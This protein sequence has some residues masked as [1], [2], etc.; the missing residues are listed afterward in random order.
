MFSCWQGNKMFSLAW[1]LLVFF[2]FSLKL[3]FCMKH[4]SGSVGHRKPFISECFLQIV[5]PEG[6]ILPSIQW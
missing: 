5:L 6:D 4:V 1:P 2:F 3:I